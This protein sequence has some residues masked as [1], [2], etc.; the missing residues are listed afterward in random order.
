[1]GMNIVYIFFSEFE[2]MQNA[3]YNETQYDL[4][5]QNENDNDQNQEDFSHIH[6]NRSKIGIDL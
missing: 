1:M 4:Y 2:V 3:I 5:K 6:M